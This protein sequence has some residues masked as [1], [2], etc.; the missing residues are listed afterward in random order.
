MCVGTWSGSIG[1]LQYHV[2]DF[3]YVK[4]KEPGMEPHIFFVIRLFEK[5]GAPT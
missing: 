4:N 5:D 1:E 3:V 2:G